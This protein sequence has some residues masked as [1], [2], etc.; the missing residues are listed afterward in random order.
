MFPQRKPSF[1][2]LKKAATDYL[3]KTGFRIFSEEEGRKI[4]INETEIY[5]AIVDQGYDMPEVWIGKKSDKEW[6]RIGFSLELFLAGTTKLTQKHFRK[7][8]FYDEEHCFAYYAKFLR[9]YYY[10]IIEIHPFP[11]N[12][13]EW[14][15]SNS[16]L[17]Y[18]AAEKLRKKTR[19]KQ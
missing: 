2:A 3:L 1:E 4:F 17:I 19:K 8:T 5:I 9:R 11:E 13:N 10:K 12:Y 18:G 15:R 16:S 14:A 7:G 6:I